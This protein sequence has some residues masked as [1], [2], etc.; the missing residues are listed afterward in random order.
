MQ[1][2][3][4]LIYTYKLRAKQKLLIEGIFALARIEVCNFKYDIPRK[5]H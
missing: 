2:R 1:K 3:Q 5:I 4:I